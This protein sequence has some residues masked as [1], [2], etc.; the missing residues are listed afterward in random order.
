MKCAIIENVFRVPKNVNKT[1]IV[2]TR[3]FVRIIVVLN[4]GL[5][6]NVVMVTIAV[7]WDAKRTNVSTMKIANKMENPA[8][9]TNAYT[10]A[11]PS[12]IATFT[13]S[14]VE[15]YVNTRN[16]AGA[17]HAERC[18]RTLYAIKV[19]QKRFASKNVLG[20]KVV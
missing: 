3:N 4:V 18:N 8:E 19:T 9:T 5:I 13:N 10:L 16:V 12:G 6:T 1:L 17:V 20:E 11:K 14:V 7:K 2:I 15:E